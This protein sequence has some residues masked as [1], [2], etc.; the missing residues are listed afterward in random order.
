VDLFLQVIKWLAI[1]YGAGYVLFFL[2]LFVFF[3]SQLDKEEWKLKTLLEGFGFVLLYSFL[4][5]KWTWIWLMQKCG[6]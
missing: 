1:A 6:R 4:W 3:A 5:P 2:G